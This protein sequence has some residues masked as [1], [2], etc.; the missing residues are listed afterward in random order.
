[1]VP[2]IAFYLSVV[3]G[4]REIMATRKALQLKP[5]FQLHNIMLSGGSLLLLLLMAEEVLP[6]IYEHGL[7]FAMCSSN[8]WTPVGTYLR[9]TAM[10]SEFFTEIRSLLY[11]QL[12]L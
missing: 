9:N 8:A 4:I 7:F 10:D 5:L 12:L 2:T 3:F 6:I 1:V 11:H